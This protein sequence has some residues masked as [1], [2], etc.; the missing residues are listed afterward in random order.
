LLPSRAHLRFHS[1]LQISTQFTIFTNC[2][3]KQPF[4][5]TIREHI[6]INTDLTQVVGD[7]NYEL[8]NLPTTFGIGNV[9]QVVT[10]RKLAQDNGVYDPITG[11]YSSDTEDGIV[12]YFTSDVVSQSDYYPFGMMLPNRNSSDGADYR[13][14]FNGMEKDDEINEVKGSSYDFGAR[15]YNPRVGRWLSGDPLEAKYPSLCTYVYTANNPI[16][17]IDPDGRTIEPTSS[18]TN[19]KGYKTAMKQM[20]SYPIIQANIII[21]ASY[22]NMPKTQEKINSTATVAFYLQVQVR[23]MTTQEFAA[24]NGQGI[25]FSTAISKSTKKHTYNGKVVHEYFVTEIALSN[26][27]FN[28]GVI[29][30]EF[31]HAGQ[32]LYYKEQGDLKNAISI[33]LEAKMIKVYAIWEQNQNLS[34]PEL[35]NKMLGMGVQAYELDIL[36]NFTVTDNKMENVEFDKDVLY[37]FEKGGEVEFSDPKIGAVEAALKNAGKV[38]EGIY[39]NVEGWQANG[40]IDVSMKYFKK[41]AQESN[42]K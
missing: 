7:K 39:K 1:T 34:A 11:L 27:G 33:E 5:S 12:D 21:L 4:T 19:N 15:L 22:N 13:Y 40:K 9:L 20:Q 8:S 41:L 3:K 35:A 10:D 31:L 26:Q 29:S 16:F 32:K 18:I 30:E 6:N 25:G 42:G 28:Y 14:A 17:F 38:I 23:D 36:M 24:T 37:Y 2:Q